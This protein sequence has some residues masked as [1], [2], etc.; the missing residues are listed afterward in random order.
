MTH[1]SDEILLRALDGELPPGM[2]GVQSHLDQC[3]ECRSR[4][5]VLQDTSDAVLGYSMQLSGS[6]AGGNQRNELLAALAGRPPL[7][8]PRR[9]IA[10]P[11]IA[12]LLLTAAAAILLSIGVRRPASVR[13]DFIRLPYSDENLSAEGSVVLEVEVPR[14]ALLLAGTP[15][16]AT[17]DRVKAEVMVGAD[18]LAR[19]I[20]FLD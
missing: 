17:G 3:D 19:A 10:K 6:R 13:S 9:H 14:T 5:A 18:G 1:L 8:T 20:R 15:V 12:G 7:R 11:A 16:P 4:V 2:R